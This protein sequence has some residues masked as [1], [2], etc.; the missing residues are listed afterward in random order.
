[1]RLSRIKATVPHMGDVTD[2]GKYITLWNQQADGSWK[3]AAETWS[4]DKP[5]PVVEKSKAKSESKHKIAAK[6]KT[7]SKKAVT[8]KSASKKKST[9]KSGTKK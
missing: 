2:Q 9:K 5:M 1:M 4:T 3:M 6:K 8:K 7:I